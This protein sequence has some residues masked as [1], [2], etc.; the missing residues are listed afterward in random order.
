MLHGT[1]AGQHGRACPALAD[2]EIKEASPVST[3]SPG[4][5]AAAAGWDFYPFLDKIT[6]PQGTLS[7]AGHNARNTLECSK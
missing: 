2:L 1:M 7:F 3:H 4:L 6:S 5:A